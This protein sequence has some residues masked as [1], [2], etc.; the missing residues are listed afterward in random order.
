MKIDKSK[1]KEFNSKTSI[2][3]LKPTVGSVSAPDKKHPSGTQRRF[4]EPTIKKIRINFLFR[5]V[6]ENHLLS[7]D[8]CSLVNVNDSS[9]LVSRPSPPSKAGMKIV[10]KP[11]VIPYPNN[12]KFF[13]PTATNCGKAR[14]NVLNSLSFGFGL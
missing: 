3:V 5:C 6:P 14:R 9:L 4:I 13:T 12:T 2:I 8:I 1:L 10:G 7:H 11:N